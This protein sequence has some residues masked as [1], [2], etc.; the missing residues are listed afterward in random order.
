M[1]ATPTITGHPSICSLHIWSGQLPLLISAHNFL[2]S[3]IVGQTQ[4]SKQTHFGTNV[5][6]NEQPPTAW[7]QVIPANHM[8]VKQNQL[9]IDQIT[10]RNS[11]GDAGSSCAAARQCSTHAI[12]S[13]ISYAQRYPE[14]PNLRSLG[15]NQTQLSTIVTFRATTILI[16]LVASGYT[17]YK[18]RIP[19]QLSP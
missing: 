17:T 18:I 13:T 10:V 3:K 11:T 7:Q 2:F 14:Q 6:I 16:S 1:P 12:G 5:G 9:T 4:F 8:A 15:T 19:S